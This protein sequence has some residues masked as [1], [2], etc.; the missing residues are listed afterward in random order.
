MLLEKKVI[1]ITGAGRGIGRSV[2]LACAKEGASLGLIARTL[3]EVRETSDLVVKAAPGVKT[4]V[5]AADV[6]DAAAMEAAMAAIHADLGA[7][8]GVIANAGASLKAVTH[9]CD[10]AQFAH[11]MNVNVT[12]VFTTF[13]ASYPRLNKDDKKQKARFM[14]T[15]SAAYPN[16]M[17]KFA[18]YTASKWAVVGLQK[19]LAME[20][21]SENIGFITILPTMVDTRLLRGG[22]AGDGNKPPTVM[23]PHELD[24][25]YVFAMSDLANKLS[26]ELI[27]VNDFQQVKKVLA[28]APAD[29]KRD[30]ET[31]K[32]YLEEKS[33][34]VYKGLKKL[35]ALAEFLMAN[36]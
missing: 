29:V 11:V 6:T 32:P 26:D 1:V 18:A 30:W 23:E 24:A 2:A 14:I 22:K 34:T 31:F 5:Q 13:K 8:T 28:E 4:S 21:T 10:P 9:E 33:P 16:G 12:G 36:P 20:Y 3:E 35:K 17:A 7:F 25:Y 15:G 19:A 27:D